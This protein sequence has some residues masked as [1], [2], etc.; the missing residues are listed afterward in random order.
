MIRTTM[1]AAAA[2]LVLAAAPAAAGNSYTPGEIQAYATAWIGAN[3]MLQEME[4]KFDAALTEDEV[5]ALQAEATAATVAAVQSAGLTLQQ[6]NDITAAA[7]EDAAL[8]AKV[9]TEIRAQLK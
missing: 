4:A 6:Y 9:E 8:K 3:T 2:S 5:D 7:R 1:L